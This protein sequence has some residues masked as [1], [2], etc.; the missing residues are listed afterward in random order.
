MANMNHPGLTFGAS[1]GA[2]GYEVLLCEAGL[3]S[4]GNDSIGD[5][6]MA[7]EKCSLTSKKQSKKCYKI[8]PQKEVGCCVMGVK[9]WE[10]FLCW[11]A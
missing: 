9:V 8:L 7:S 3:C 4:Y 6:R 1:C 2:G 5:F 11:A 10:L